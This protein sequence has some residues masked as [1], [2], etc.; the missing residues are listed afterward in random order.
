MNSFHQALV[1]IFLYLLS[2]M[3]IAAGIIVPAFLGI[4]NIDSIRLIAYHQQSEKE[5][6]S[7]ATTDKQKMSTFLTNFAS[8]RLQRIRQEKTD[9]PPPQ[10]AIQPKQ[11]V[12]DPP[13]T[14]GGR[15]LGTIIDDD[16]KFSFAIIQMPNSNVR[17]VKNLSAIDDVS[18]EITIQ[19]V[20]MNKVL[21]NC[22]GVTQVLDIQATRP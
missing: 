21:L 13:L 9:A 16:P 18:P 22:R 1:R 5:M 20:H 15:L 11:P 8:V 6:A 14:F 7:I 3:V 12:Q 17:L 10:P 19:E 4:A 2:F